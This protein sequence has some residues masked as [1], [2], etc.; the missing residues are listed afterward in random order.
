MKMLTRGLFSQASA[1]VAA[2]RDKGYEV[3][4]HTFDDEPDYTFVEAFRDA[5]VTHGDVYAS[6]CAE[7]DRVRNIIGPLGGDID[8]CGPPPVDHVPFQYVTPI[9]NIDGLVHG[10]YFDR[11]AAVADAADADGTVFRCVRDDGGG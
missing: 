4:T 7:F 3:L 10:P 11:T 2:L 9:S 5:P 8:D 1:G 6:E